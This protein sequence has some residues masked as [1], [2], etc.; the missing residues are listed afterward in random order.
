MA[1]IKDSIVNITDEEIKD[2]KMYRLY[3]GLTN[4]YNIYLRLK[5]G[6][7]VKL[8]ITK[9]FPNKKVEVINWRIMGHGQHTK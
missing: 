8:V 3:S 2:A 4:T 7:I 6:R 5:G 9:E 1:N